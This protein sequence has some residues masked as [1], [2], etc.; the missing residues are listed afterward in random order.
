MRARL[1]GEF[2]EGYRLKRFTQTHRVKIS[3]QDLSQEFV[4]K[5][6]EKQCLELVIRES[7]E[8]LGIPRKKA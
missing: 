7:L 3:Q 8:G 4:A 6:L 2:P 5:H 1:G